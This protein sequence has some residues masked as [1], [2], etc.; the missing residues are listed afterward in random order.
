MSS[1]ALL[2]EQ[3]LDMEFS[4]AAWAVERSADAVRLALELR[5]AV[6]VVRMALADEP[7]CWGGQVVNFAE[8]RQALKVDTART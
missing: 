8:R 7:T 2:E 3:L 5:R 4:G 6:S 1:R